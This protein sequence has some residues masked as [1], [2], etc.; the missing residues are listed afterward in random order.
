MQDTLTLFRVYWV[1]VEWSVWWSNR[2]VLSRPSL[3]MLPGWN[4]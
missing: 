4:S 3:S 2:V 1:A